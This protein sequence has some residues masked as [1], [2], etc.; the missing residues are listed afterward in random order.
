MDNMIRR[1]NLSLSPAVQMQGRVWAPQPDQF[2]LSIHALCLLCQLLSLSSICFTPIPLLT[3]LP[4]SRCPWPN[5][6]F[7]TTHICT[8]WKCLSPAFLSQLLRSSTSLPFWRELPSQWRTSTHVTWEGRGMFKHVHIGMLLRPEG[9]SKDW[10]SYLKGLLW[11]VDL[12]ASLSGSPTL[13]RSW[14]AI[15]LWALLLFLSQ[16]GRQ[17]LCSS[18]PLVPSVP[19]P[20][21]SRSDLFHSFPCTKLWYTSEV[22]LLLFLVLLNMYGGPSQCSKP[23]K[24]N[25]R[26]AE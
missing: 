23:G 12:L 9:G 26:H 13:C 8:Y 22:S 17:A 21:P 14:L 25:R 4:T 19:M 5:L 2:R 11:E 15:A 24:R 7:P 1:S 10:E 3:S 16:A 18:H 20:L 6:P